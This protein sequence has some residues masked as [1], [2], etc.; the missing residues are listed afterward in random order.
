M[1][2]ARSESA[3]WTLAVQQYETSLLPLESKP[4]RNLLIVGCGRG[5]LAALARARGWR[6]VGLD[7]SP[8]A[9]CRAIEQ[10]GLD[11]RAGGLARHREA[12]GRFD[13]VLCGNLETSWDPAAVLRDARTVLNTGGAVC[14]D[15]S[16][17]F[18]DWDPSVAGVRPNA[19]DAPLNVFDAE[20]LGRLLSACGLSSNAIHSD[21]RA[22]TSQ[23]SANGR[24]AFRWIPRFLF[25][26]IVRLWGLVAGGAGTGFSH[27]EVSDLSEAD[28]RIEKKASHDASHFG[29]ANRLLAVATRAAHAG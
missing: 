12:L 15:V 3:A 13:V 23:L 26:W 7:P 5:H 1:C 10:F 16:D 22:G 19:E 27:S 14:V 21:E 28:S 24:G 20:S 17:G 8:H 9:V 4:G 25:R 2:E 29:R 6:V 18:A 11:A